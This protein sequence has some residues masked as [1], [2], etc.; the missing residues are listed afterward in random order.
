MDFGNVFL[1]YPLSLRYFSRKPFVRRRS[2]SDADEGDTARGF[3]ANA[4][5]TTYVCSRPNDLSHDTSYVR[6]N[7]LV[8]D[9]IDA[10]DVT[11]PCSDATRLALRR[12]CTCIPMT[13]NLYVLIPRENSTRNLDFLQRE[14]ARYLLIMACSANT[15]R[16]D[17]SSDPAVPSSSSSRIGSVSSKLELIMEEVFSPLGSLYDL[18]D[19]F[20]SPSNLHASGNYTQS[21]SPATD[22]SNLCDLYAWRFDVERTFRRVHKHLSDNVSNWSN[23]FQLPVL[24]DDDATRFS[25]DVLVEQR[26]RLS[27]LERNRIRA[28]LMTKLGKNMDFLGTVDQVTSK[29]SNRPNVS[30]N[31]DLLR[32]FAMHELNELGTKSDHQLT[33]P[34]SGVIDGEHR[35]TTNKVHLYSAFAFGEWC[36]LRDKVILRV[37]R[38]IFDRVISSYDSL[39]NALADQPA[40]ADALWQTPCVFL[41]NVVWDVETIS[42][43]PG[44]L[45]RGVNR[46]EKLVSVA[47]TIDRNAAPYTTADGSSRPSCNCFVFA[48]VPHPIANSE[49]SDIGSLS[50][51]ERSGDRLPFPV[52]PEPRIFCY[53][54]ERA[55][56]V[57]VVA[58]LSSQAL[59]FSALYSLKPEAY[60]KYR[61]LASFL[62]GHNSVGYD[63]LFLH[64][65]CTFFALN[66]IAAHLTRNV[67]RHD[68]SEISDLYTFNESQLCLDT[69]LF[70][71]TRMRH[72]SSFDLASVLA[73]YR[74]DLTKGTLDARSIRFFYNSLGNERESLR[75]GYD[76]AHKR[77]AY[78]RDF[79]RYNLYDCL[80]L[81]DLLSKLSFAVFANTLMQYFHAPFNTSCYC[82]NSRLLPN[83]IIGDMLEHGREFL[84]V[85]RRSN[86]SLVSSNAVDFDELF[87]SV[88]SLLVE[89][90]RNHPLISAQ[91]AVQVFPAY[92]Y[93]KESSVSQQ[94]TDDASSSMAMSLSA[95]SRASAPRKRSYVS[96]VSEDVRANISLAKRNAQNCFYGVQ[97]VLQFSRNL[98]AS[99]AMVDDNRDDAITTTCVSNEHFAWTRDVSALTRDQQL[100][101]TIVPLCERE[102]DLLRVDEKTYIGGLNYADPCHLK[103]PFL[104]DY[105]SFYPS[106]IRHYQLDFNNVA[107]F[108]V[109]KLLMLARSLQRLELLLASRT[110]RIFDYTG[111]SDTARYVNLFVF[112]DPSFADIYT[113]LPHCRREWYSGVEITNVPLLIAS[114]KHLTRRVLV[115][116][117]KSSSTVARIVSEA[118]VRRTAWKKLRKANP[119]DRVLESRELMEKLLANGTYGY[120]NF[121]RSVIFSRATA[122]AVT[123]LCRNAFARTRFIIESDELMRRFDHRMSRRFRALVNYIDTDGC[124]VSF[125]DRLDNDEEQMTTTVPSTTTELSLTTS[126]QE[127]KRHLFTLN[128]SLDRYLLSD[129]PID[130]RRCSVFRSAVDFD[131]YAERVS[132]SKDRYVELVN[133]ML[134]MQHVRLAAEENRSVAASVFGRKKYTLF[135]LN[136]P[137]LVDANARFL[138][139][140]TGFEKNAPAPIKLLYDRLLRNVMTINH[141][142]G[143]NARQRFLAKIVDHRAFLYALF[144]SLHDLWRDALRDNRVAQFATKIPLNVRSTGGK[145]ADFI[146]T[147]LREHQ[148]DPGD[149]VQVLRVY[150]I[151]VASLDQRPRFTSM[152]TNLT[153]IVY[154]VT[155]SRIILLDELKDRLDDFF[156]DLRYFLGGHLTYMYQ[157]VEGFKTMRS[158]NDLLDI[159]PQL[160][161]IAWLRSSDRDRLLATARARCGYDDGCAQTTRD[162]NTS[163]DHASLIELLCNDSTMCM[164]SLNA[165]SSFFYSTW[166]WERVLREKHRAHFGPSIFHA[167]VWREMDETRLGSLLARSNKLLE[168]C[169][170][171][172]LNDVQTLAPDQRNTVVVRANDN[173]DNGRVRFTSPFPLLFADNFFRKW[174]F[175]SVEKRNAVDESTRSTLFVSRDL[176]KDDIGRFFRHRVVLYRTI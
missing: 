39:C 139:K 53:R 106:I 19:M 44:T 160:E 5:A 146:T 130:D 91:M 17:G 97:R 64:N 50:L 78:F 143:L 83:L 140:K 65:R 96:C 150:P 99:L 30:M 90:N 132:A 116:W 81:S 23:V 134:D 131:E 54:D 136:R 164:R 76:T 79:L 102:S 123:L 2:D 121:S 7:G 3:D 152:L 40:T 161:P 31:E 128:C 52:V 163:H 88:R 167:Y 60:K 75:L 10:N 62:V 80:S 27:Q 85:R 135:K 12:V 82:G 71:M 89:L 48:L 63:F 100:M 86:L 58:F 15:E 9:V 122:A 61:N 38:E 158:R 142:A 14:I 45:P 22:F 29:L 93:Y 51:F 119:N 109:A 25:F 16:N 162:R 120:L 70:L 117:N 154:N 68:V 169:T 1:F 125:S 168:G 74:C 46:D 124:I 173:G 149:R 112:Q 171:V 151:S 153:T 69:M 43:R 129:E 37:D 49:F 133:E 170:T 101:R 115:V 56:L 174:L 8:P 92:D 114:S 118:L 33:Q 141:V 94:T 159:A 98:H 77:I 26:D 73:V 127:T 172:G 103:N 67:R 41:P 166:M 57:D 95:S 155:D 66:S 138:L 47:V 21:T 35:D 105:N 6:I 36:L 55:L 145:L 111:E 28:N 42:A 24:F 13:F 148:Y 144:D 34:S 176:T 147:T 175:D 110:L 87:A 107:V 157:C 137:S 165:I 84:T 156:P 11:R 126:D 104:M 20:A 72:L 4:D 18:A 59:L 32:E 108:S 113:P